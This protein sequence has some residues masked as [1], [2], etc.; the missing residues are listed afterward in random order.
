MFINR[1]RVC[2]RSLGAPI[3]FPM[4]SLYLFI[5]AVC[6]CKHGFGTLVV[7]QNVFTNVHAS[8]HNDTAVDIG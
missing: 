5:N 2:K 1:G 8:T 3:C 7:T 4:F 6:V